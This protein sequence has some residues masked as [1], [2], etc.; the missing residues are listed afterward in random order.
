M[1]RK[2]LRARRREIEA[3]IAKLR[4]K[5]KDKRERQDDA[6]T[7]NRADELADDIDALVA[8]LD[9]LVPRYKKLGK[10]IERLAKKAQRRKH[11][12]SKHFLYSEFNTKDGTQI[13]EASKP[14]LREWCQ[15]IGE[16]ARAR[17]GTVHITSGFRHASYNA[18]IGGAT[19]SVHIW[20]YPG[21]DCKAIAVDWWAESGGPRDWFDFADG[22][23]DG[24][25][26]YP[27]SGFT[28]SDTR[29]NIGWPDATWSG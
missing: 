24:R 19:N 22:R 5:V 25:G 2:K 3:R 1:G 18:A 7:D 6:K 27:N 15:R 10:K 29:N 28:H 26:Y 4:A 12:A 20:D 9:R 17:F 23:A 14:A 16:P 21:R 11:Y 13:P 8:K